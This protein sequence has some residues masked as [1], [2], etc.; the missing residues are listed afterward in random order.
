MLNGKAYFVIA[1]L[2]LAACVWLVWDRHW[3][4]VVSGHAA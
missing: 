4:L 3:R 2:L 1:P